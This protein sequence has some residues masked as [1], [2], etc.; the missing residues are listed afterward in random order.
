VRRPDPG[1]VAT[2]VAAAS[3]L[4]GGLAYLAHRELFAALGFA[5]FEMDIDQAA[6]TLRVFAFLFPVAGI[7]SA[8]WVS[9]SAAITALRP[10][11]SGGGEWRYGL[12]VVLLLAMLFG[13]DALPARVAGY[14]IIAFGAVPPLTFVLAQ[15]PGESANDF[16]GRAA[17]SASWATVASAG[18]IV[19]VTSM[20]WL[21]GGGRVANQL[22]D[23]GQATGGW[24]LLLDV[25]ALPVEVIPSDAVPG[26]R[27]LTLVGVHDGVALLLE[28]Q[29][30]KATS[31]LHRIPVDR[32]DSLVAR[33][34]ACP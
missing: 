1:S 29:C 34:A 15:V 7:L 26:S 13:L 6:V 12:T 24:A 28:P 17:A 22:L 20:L 10:G 21:V 2:V 23:S 8:A 16:R 5:T 18:L 11:R 30:G 19:A 3:V 25:S 27:P 9:A 33:P 4:S 32:L 14:L 31:K